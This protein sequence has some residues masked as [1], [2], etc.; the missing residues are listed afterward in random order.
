[1]GNPDVLGLSICIP[2]YNRARLLRGTLGSLAHVTVPEG[3]HIELIVL[4]NNCTDETPLVIEQFAR[5][6]PFPV[7]RVAVSQQGTGHGRN[8]ALMEA[9]FEHVAYLDDDVEVAPEWIQAYFDSVEKLNADCVVGPV[10]PR[11]EAAVPPYFTRRVIDSV[12]STYSL[13]GDVPKRLAE[14]VAHEIP[15]CNFAARRQVAREIGGFNPALDR[16]AAGLVAGGDSEFGC[17]LVSAHK[18]VVYHPGFAILHVITAEKLNPDYLRRRWY[19]T[20]VTQR[21]LGGSSMGSGRKLRQ[22]AGVAR[23]FAVAAGLRLLGRKGRS[24][25][26]ELEAWQALGFLRGR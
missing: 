20:G 16:I 22:A 12:S 21:L 5:S 6:V 3:A 2:T 8:R 18:R 23:R 14:D 11:F 19:G 4:D 10:R 9:T 1:M 7:R 13:K 26:R 25:E 15:G 17:R 24:F